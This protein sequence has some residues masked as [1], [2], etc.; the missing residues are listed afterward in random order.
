MK[1]AGFH[2]ANWTSLFGSGLA[3]LG[4]C[5]FAAGLCLSVSFTEIGL[6]LV[7]ISLLIQNS[8]FFP[9]KSGTAPKFGAGQP[10][11]E[12]KIC[13]ERSPNAPVKLMQPCGAFGKRALQIKIP[14][15]LKFLSNELTANPLFLPWMF[16]LLAGVA[17]AF[18]GVEQKTS[19]GY[20]PSDLIKCAAFFLLCFA[21]GIPTPLIPLPRAG[22]GPSVGA[23]DKTANWYLAGAL[24][25]AILGIGQA[26][27]AMLEGNFSFRAHGT[28]HPVTFGE[29]IALAMSFSL[30]RIAAGENSGR[31]MPANWVATGVLLLG[32]VLSQTRGAYLGIFVTLGCLF[33]FD[34]RSRKVAF[35]AMIVLVV[36]ESAVIFVNRGIYHRLVSIPTG[37]S[38]AVTS[39]SG[40]NLPEK[41]A[42][43]DVA[44]NS[45]IELWKASLHII[46]DNPVLGVGPSNV[47]NVFNNY[48]PEAIEGQTG[49]S[50]V[51]SLY[52]QQ[53]AERGLIG[54]GALLYLFAAMFRLAWKRF[55]ETRNEYT[56]A[57]V[58]ILPGFF[59]I[60]LT[61]TS[62]QHALPAFSVLF[63][64]AAALN[65]KTTETTEHT[66]GSAEVAENREK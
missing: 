30:C 22:D 23:A 59:V 28:I 64:L 43:E 61:E 4:L 25:A 65:G 11:T 14:Q 45:R 29:L 1:T 42:S 5:L 33:G 57:C 50:N 41:Q 66:E 16:Y 39:F 37:I 38:D 54:L 26:I 55:R 51:H 2:I 40:K 58:C 8:P 60:N 46:R 49:W 53:A 62:F 56:L 17:A 6:G 47:K 44:T 35:L 15:T 13:R 12:T 7:L 52:L 9:L 31:S 48:H 34:R 63:L 27:I 32:L 36:M 19:F 10:Q 20:L 21:L 18:M 3:G 24:A